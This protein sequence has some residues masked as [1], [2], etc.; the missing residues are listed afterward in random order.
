MSS[1]G[2]AGVDVEAG[3]LKFEEAGEDAADWLVAVVVDLGE[4]LI[5]SVGMLA[6]ETSRTDESSC[7]DG[8]LLEVEG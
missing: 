4:K 8:L 6:A 7:N 5:R 3:I 1:C 2:T